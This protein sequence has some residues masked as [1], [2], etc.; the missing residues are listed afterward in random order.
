MQGTKIFGIVEKT[1]TTE[2]GNVLLSEYDNSPLN[3]KE[4]RLVFPLV[5]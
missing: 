2:L 4:C 3:H 5:I 1:L